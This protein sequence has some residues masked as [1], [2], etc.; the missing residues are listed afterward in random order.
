MS[1]NVVC[2]GLTSLR[3]RSAPSPGST[4]RRCT[5][6]SPRWGNSA[7]A[8]THIVAI[9]RLTKPVFPNFPWSLVR[10]V[11]G[12]GSTVRSRLRNGGLHDRRFPR[13]KTHPPRGSSAR[14]QPPGASETAPFS[15]RT[16]PHRARLL[17]IF[18][19]APL[20]RPLP[21]KPN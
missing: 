3:R 6:S 21:N 19:P 10:D 20:H 7:A 5:H 13:R 12:Y 18:K 17:S 2:I 16:S 15:S 9:P 8:P 1:H 11:L 14:T 4:L